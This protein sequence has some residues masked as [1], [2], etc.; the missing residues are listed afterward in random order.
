M[1]TARHPTSCGCRRCL[2]A[3]LEQQRAA[4]GTLPAQAEDPIVEAELGPLPSADPD[5][6]DLRREEA[7]RRARQREAD[8]L[9]AYD[10]E[11][12]MP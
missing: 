12:Q 7:E 2:V 8:A 6:Y 3:D 1:S 4:I 9:A 10:L 5:P 11:G